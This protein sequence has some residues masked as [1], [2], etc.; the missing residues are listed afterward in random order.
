MR[1]NHMEEV[2]QF[3]QLFLDKCKQ[4]EHKEGQTN[5]RKSLIRLMENDN[6]ELYQQ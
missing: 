3:K 5:Q 6:I 2:T 1:R 4:E